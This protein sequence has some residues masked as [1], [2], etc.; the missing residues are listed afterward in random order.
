M[1]RKKKE[2][3]PLL[4]RRGV[5]IKIFFLPAGALISFVLKFMRI[6]LFWLE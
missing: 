3:N 1:K 2:N 4:Y 5:F 6:K